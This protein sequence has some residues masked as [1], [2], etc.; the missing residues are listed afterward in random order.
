MGRRWSSFPTSQAEPPINR[1][2]CRGGAITAYG[3]KGECGQGAKDGGGK[4][5]RNRLWNVLRSFW[6]RWT[7]VVEASGGGRWCI[8]TLPARCAP[9]GAAN[10]RG[11]A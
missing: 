2:E 4:D 5:G 3:A 1:R 6:R 7:E 10:M 11:H 9:N 8:L